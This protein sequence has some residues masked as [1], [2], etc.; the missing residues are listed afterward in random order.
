MTEII[1]APSKVLFCYLYFLNRVYITE[2]LS[3]FYDKDC[4]IS[5][6]LMFFKNLTKQKINRVIVIDNPVGLLSYNKSNIE[7]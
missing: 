6:T 7:N 5:Y 2:N 3:R 1:K 4:M